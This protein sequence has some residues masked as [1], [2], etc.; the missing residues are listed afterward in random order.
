MHQHN[1]K[2]ER[3]QI[4]QKGIIRCTPQIE[5][6]GLFF[7]LIVVSVGHCRHHARFYLNQ[8]IIA[9]TIKIKLSLRL[10]ECMQSHIK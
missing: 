9:E 2:S 7:R 6:S 1:Q 4:R 8:I 5:H 3:F 10:L